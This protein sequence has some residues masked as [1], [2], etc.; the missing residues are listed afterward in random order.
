MVKKVHKHI[1]KYKIAVSGAAETGHCDK[2]A[3]EKAE[4]VG[5][6]IAK[7]GAVLMTGATTGIPYWAAKG[8]KAEG[9]LVFGLS[10]G[11]S[12]AD[13]VKSYRL[14][15]DYHDA[16]IF[17]GFNYAGRNLLLTRSAEA[18][19]VIC[20]RIGTLNEFTIAF[21]D[22]KIIGVLEGTGGTA[23]QLRE[24]IDKSH[25]GPGKVIFSSN[26]KKLVEQVGEMIKKDRYGV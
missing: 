21:E 7:M 25:R 1:I 13:H 10:P 5:R 12:E 8:A 9:G 17:T 15:V 16:I 20:G 24:I 6:E 23:D 19:I 4:Q 26:P 22:K 3:I 18:V 14:P 11:A 2:S